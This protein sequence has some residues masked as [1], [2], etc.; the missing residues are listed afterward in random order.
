MTA[1]AGA[2]SIDLHVHT[3]F[4]DGTLAPH[5]LVACGLHKGLAVLSITD[6]DTVEGVPEALMAA[7]GTSLHIVPGVEISTDMKGCELHILGYLVDPHHDGLLRT[8]AQFRQQRLDRAL[9]IVSKLEDLGLPLSWKRVLALAGPGVVGR[10]HIAR[11]LQ[12]AGHVHSLREAFDA[13]LGREGPAYVPRRKMT[14]AQAIGL[15]HQAGGVPV[16]AHPWGVLSALPD[17]V[18]SGLRGLEVYYPGYSPEVTA[19]LQRLAR[20]HHLA[21]TGGSDFHR[22]DDAP[23]NQLGHVVV[24]RSCLDELEANKPAAHTTVQATRH[25]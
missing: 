2:G 24:P 3:L 9:N 14:P 20:E 19:E 15:I 23:E 25:P 21:C 13:Y 10:P 8:L 16:L 18:R 11:A 4:S 7:E 17:L 5:E 6:H 12:E 22:P 1:R